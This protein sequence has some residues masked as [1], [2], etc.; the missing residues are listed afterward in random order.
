MV[1]RGDVM[2]IKKPV[3]KNKKGSQHRKVKLIDMDENT[4]L[5][6]MEQSFADEFMKDFNQT[7]AAIRA[8]YAVSNARHVASDM[9]KQVNIHAYIERKL[10]EK[11]I[12]TGIESDRILRE[13]ARIA[14][15][16][17]STFINDDGSLS[18]NISDDD[19]AAIAGVKVKRTTF[20]EDG[21]SIEREV[22]IWD[23]NK[24]LELLMKFA[25][26]STEFEKR[27]EVEKMKI[28]QKQEELEIAKER[29]AMDKEKMARG[30]GPIFEGDGFENSLLTAAS[31]VWGVQ[32][33][34]KNNDEVRKNTGE[35]PESFGDVAQKED[36]S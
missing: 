8:G 16:N 21:E 3:N 17:A 13:A 11:S 15:S 23:K 36:E 28:K 32:N 2:P 10:A 19:G 24:A 20:G 5:L 26:A 1:S 6:A 33:A 35:T 18:E 7:A 30:I 4:P 14:F 22:K 25:K 31:L 9:R 12:R 34:Q 27:M 29:L